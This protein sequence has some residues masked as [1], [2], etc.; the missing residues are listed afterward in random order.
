LGSTHVSVL[1]HMHTLL[2]PFL[3]L[4]EHPREFVVQVV[5]L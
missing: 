3:P 1:L 2:V 5:L 4:I